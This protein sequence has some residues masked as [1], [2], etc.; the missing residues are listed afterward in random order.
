MAPDG[1]ART[2]AE[3]AYSAL[4]DAIITGGLAPGERL[5]IDRL[6]DDLDMSPMPI[7]EALHRLDSAGL[8]ESVP[9]R[10]ARVTELSI[11]DLHE[12]YE[13]ASRS[14]R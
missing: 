1:G 12:V 7:R 9:H 10:G 8:V 13:G 6:A 2:L 5:P 11:G 4:H 14:S 3:R